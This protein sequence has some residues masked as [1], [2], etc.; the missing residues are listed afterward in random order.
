MDTGIY[1][2]VCVGQIYNQLGTASTVLSWRSDTR[3][4]HRRYHRAGAVDGATFCDLTGMQR[5]S[6]M[7][8][9]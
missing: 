9:Q 4:V 6:A 5:V 2:C 8:R 7:A 3:V 1:V